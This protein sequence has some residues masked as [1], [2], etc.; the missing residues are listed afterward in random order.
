MPARHGPGA[1]V[2]PGT[3]VVVDVNVLDAYSDDLVPDLR[4]P[5]YRGAP[6]PRSSGWQKR[7]AKTN[8]NLALVKVVLAQVAK[9]AGGGVT[10]LITCTCKFSVILNYM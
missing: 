1:L 8:F 2:P 9:R 6:S 4:R 10:A 3:C 7:R 5:P